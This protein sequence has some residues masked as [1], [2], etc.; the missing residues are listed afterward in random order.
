MISL[1][2]VL[3]QAASAAAAAAAFNLYHSQFIIN[4]INCLRIEVE[5]TFDYFMKTINIAG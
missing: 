2:M 5:K 3:Q 4:L 1:I